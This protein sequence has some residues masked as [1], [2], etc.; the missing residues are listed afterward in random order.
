MLATR[1]K[2]LL[3]LHASPIPVSGGA[4]RRLLGYLEYFKNRKSDLTVDVIS[5][6]PFN[7]SDWNIEQQQAVREFVDRLHLYQ[8]TALDH[9]YA[10]SKSIYYQKLLKQ[11]I[12]IDSDT[13]TPPGY[14]RFAQHL[15]QKHSYDIVLINYLSFA[16]LA[17]TSNIEHTKTLIDIHDIASQN[18]LALKNIGF[19]KH[20]KL[21]Y[22]EDFAKE[23]DVLKQLDGVI[24]NSKKE[25]SDLAPYLSADKLCLVPHLV[26]DA[27]AIARLTPYAQRSFVYDLLFVGSGQHAPNVE[28]INF[29]LA[30]IFPK[31]VY[32]KPDVKL[33]IAG[34]VSDFSQFDLSLTNN[35]DLLGYIDDLSTVYSQSR[36]AICP[37]L[38]GAG[39]KV[40]LQEAMVYALPIITTTVGA[41]GLSLLNNINAIITDEPE[42]YAKQILRLLDHP[43]LAN[44]LSDAITTTF[45]TDYSN[46]AVYTKLDQ[47]FGITSQFKVSV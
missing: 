40:K 38:N 27:G 35:I 33:A 32:Y 2:I 29:F 42:D 21:D 9:L 23:V 18:R 7:S 31:I 25:L 26:E 11:L 14:L 43:E 4:T 34:T 20:L 36:T 46:Q 15:M 10:R 24:A 37:L 39:T 22:A 6:I 17:T 1:K 41:S 47:L 5:H 12:P 19:R 13:A 45:Q 28:G 16:R 8:G 3:H 30:E 44:R